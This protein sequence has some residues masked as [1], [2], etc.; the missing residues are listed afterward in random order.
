MSVERRC[1]FVLIASALWAASWASAGA[2]PEADAV[3]RRIFA[4][5]LDRVLSDYV[6]RVDAGVLVAKA[7]DGMASLS[8]P[9]GPDV[10]GSA[11][12]PA[13]GPALSDFDA[14]F[15][16]FSRREA[17]AA[18]LRLVQ[19]AI[20]GMMTA[21]DG[22][23]FYI[24]QQELRDSSLQEQ[25]GGVGLELTL[26]SGLI[27]VVRSMEGAVAARAGL[28]CGD[29]IIAI[30]GAPVAGLTLPE[31][32]GRLRGRVHSAVTLSLGSQ[33]GKWRA[34]I[35]LIREVVRP[36]SVR[37]RTDDDIGYIRLS[38]FNEQT[39]EAVKA[40]IDAVHAQIAPARLKGWALDVRDNHGGLLDQ[41]V[42]VADL[43]LDGGK[44]VAARGRSWE[45]TYAATA[46]DLA[47][48]KPIVVLVN[49]RTAS[50]AEMLAGALQE[51]KRA[52]LVG[53]PSIGS[54]T[55]QTIFPLTP[56][57]GALRL[58]TSRLYTPAGRQIEGNGITP[59]IVVEQTEGPAADRVSR[60]CKD[61]DVWLGDGDKQLRYAID[62][63]RRT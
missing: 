53:M 36:T 16:R 14:A 42:S 10:A 60:S 41:A 33:K 34:D 57:A 31:A 55:V 19:A 49:G 56:V 6:D 37:F 22:L 26:Q 44:I 46:G 15:D 28:V 29:V 1:S 12:R 30:D 39:T 2:Q 58:T 51:N 59:D 17:G 35:E 25:I 45:D 7:I 18:G 54:G 62:F 43:F 4:Q 40:A 48:G 63:L 21:L 50:G 9:H 20:G 47:Q 3:S 5:A 24:P 32:V 11:S 23:S 61:Q 27:K 8:G 13:T 52:T 38:H